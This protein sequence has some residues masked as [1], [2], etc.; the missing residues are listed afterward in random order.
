MLLGLLEPVWGYPPW[1]SDSIAS[2]LCHLLLVIQVVVFDSIIVLRATLKRVGCVCGLDCL[3]NIGKVCG[4]LVTLILKQV[5][6]C[7]IVYESV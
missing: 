1:G 2:R 7:I 3:I 5:I 4:L 6:Y